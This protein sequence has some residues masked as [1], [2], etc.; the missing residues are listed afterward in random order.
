MGAVSAT[1]AEMQGPEFTDF[2]TGNARKLGRSLVQS[3]KDGVIS[4]EVEQKRIEFQARMR[5]L[6]G[7]RGEQWKYE[8]QYWKEHYAQ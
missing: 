5:Q 4:P 2:V 7:F 3:W 1:M 6:V 8:A